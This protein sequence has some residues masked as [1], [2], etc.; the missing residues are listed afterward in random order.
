[1]IL[2]GQLTFFVWIQFWWKSKKK[3]WMEIHILP[4]VHFSIWKSFLNITEYKI[5]LKNYYLLIITIILL[6]SLLLIYSSIRSLVSC[7][8]RDSNMFGNHFRILNARMVQ[9]II[10]MDCP[11]IKHWL[12][13]GRYPCT[14]R[15]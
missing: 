3:T 11:V 12:L 13:Y 9:S 14:A 2:D 4:F 6:L 8:Y 1:M 10:G 7:K 5:F 15:L